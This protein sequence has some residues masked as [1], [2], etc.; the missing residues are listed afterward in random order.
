MFAAGK[1]KD[2]MQ[3]LAAGDNLV[4]L[5]SSLVLAVSFDILIAQ[6]FVGISYPIFILVLLAAVY[7]NT[8]TLLAKETRSGW[9]LVF[10]VIALAMTWFIFTNQVLRMLNSLVV[11]ILLVAHI[12]LVTKNS[13]HEWFRV[14]FLKDICRGLIVRPLQNA[15]KPFAVVWALARQESD[16]ASRTVFRKVILGVVFTLPLLIIV[17]MLLAAADQ[18]FGYFID[19]IMANISIAKIIRHSLIMGIVTLPAFSFIWGLK[20]NRGEQVPCEAGTKKIDEII[21]IS[22]LCVLSSVYVLFSVIQFSYLF[23]NFAD[24]LPD[25]LTYAAYARRGF[26][27]LVAVVL[28]NTGIIVGAINFTATTARGPELVL[29][30]LNS[31]LVLSTFVMLLSAHYRMSLY[32]ESFGY[33]YLRVF[34]HGFMIMV[35]AMLCAT[36]YRVW[37]DKI[38]LAKWLAVIGLISYVTINYANVDTFIARKNVERF[39]RTGSIDVYYMAELSDEALPYLLELTYVTDSKIQQA[40]KEQIIIKRINHDNFETRIWQGYNLS[41]QQARI[42]LQEIR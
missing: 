12:L 42:L 7:G 40:A 3:G 17:V 21:V 41:E 6:P 14:Y 15:A 19:Y 1:E 11:P 28:I 31:V 33:T 10:P 32:E 30:G 4:M 16:V 2:G 35:F 26:F 37:S 13:R 20:N 5:I 34:T 25:G 22:G 38:K 23:G 27:E 39:Y 24:R 29:K 9:L 8:R 36:F 18:V